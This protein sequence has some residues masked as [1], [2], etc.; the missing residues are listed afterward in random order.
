[1]QAHKIT[2]EEELQQA[3]KIREVV[4]VQE[5]Q[6]APEEEYDEYDQTA[7]HY[8][9]LDDEQFPCGTA[10]WR[11]T[12]HGIKLERFAV[13][14]A[15][16]GKGAG[17][18]ILQQILTDIAEDYPSSRQ[19]IYLHAQVAAIPFYERFGFEKIGD[20]FEECDIQHYKMILNQ[21]F[22]TS[23]YGKY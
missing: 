7:H 8:L 12:D 6:V 5:Q 22:N 9:A 17:A 15:Y 18:C 16:R 23:N 11:N 4:F 1:M 19:T 10:R 2:G 20:R 3:F 14:E 13:L 21:T